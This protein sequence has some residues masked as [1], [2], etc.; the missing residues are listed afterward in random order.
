MFTSAGQVAWIIGG[1][2]RCETMSETNEPLAEIFSPIEL[3]DCTRTILYPADDILT[4][5]QEAFA[6]PSRQ[7]RDRFFVA[8]LIIENEKP[9]H[10]RPFHEKMPL[11]PR[12]SRWRIPA[13]NR[14]GAADD[15]SGAH[16][17]LR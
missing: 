7:S 5:M 8:V 17:Q 1:H 9:G 6:D 15:N 4:I 16:C 3:G 13:R 10:S 12:A 2:C 14:S 11:D